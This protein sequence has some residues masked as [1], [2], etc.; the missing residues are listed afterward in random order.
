VRF[1][2]I[3]VTALVSLSHA[4][5]SQT[6]LGDG[7]GTAGFGGTCCNWTAQ[8]NVALDSCPADQLANHPACQV[9][10]KAQYDAYFAARNVIPDAEATFM[11]YMNA[12]IAISGCTSA[13]INGTWP[14][15]DASIK[16]IGLLDQYIG[17]HGNKWPD[18]KSSLIL[19]D[20]SGNGHA[21]GATK[22]LQRL[23]ELLQ[24]YRT[25]IDQVLLGGAPFTWPASSIAPPQC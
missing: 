7:N 22:D 21:F 10:T 5:A 4:A 2:C 20:S 13:A 19:K 17:G 1:I 3:L 11:F 24:D 6:Y 9:I 15:D 12:G 18:G 8:S 14:V 23:F 16:S 25:A